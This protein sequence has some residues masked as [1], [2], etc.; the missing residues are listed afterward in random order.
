MCSN[1]GP[2]PLDNFES[3]ER[4][5]T[6]ERARSSCD[7]GVS[8]HHDVLPPGLHRLIPPISI[9]RCKI[10]GPSLH[11]PLW[12]HQLSLV[13]AA[14]GFVS[15]RDGR[16]SARKAFL[17]RFAAVCKTRFLLAFLS[18]ML[19]QGMTCAHSYRK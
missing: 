7:F 18:W 3:D 19:Q 5:L 6:R 10:G 17:V 2:D 13:T 12:Q 8:D 1:S 14:K 11:N 4:G 9:S 15:S 16:H